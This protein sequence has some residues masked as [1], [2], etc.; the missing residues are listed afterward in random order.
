MA[1]HRK[2]RRTLG[3]TAFLGTATAAAAIALAAPATAAPNE[4]AGHPGLTSPDSGQPGLTS[5]GSD[6]AQP[7]LTSPAPAGEQPAQA[8]VAPADSGAY[9]YP[10]PSYPVPVV[11]EGTAPV[12]S[13][14][15]TSETPSPFNVG[16]LHAPTPVAPVTPVVP[17]Q[18]S[19]D[20][21]VGSFRVNGSAI[22]PKVRNSINLHTAVA[23]ANTE[24][25]WNSVGVAPDRS[26]R[27]AA[28][29]VAGAVGGGA[30]GA[31][32]VGAPVAAMGGGVGA[33]V[34]GGVGSL[35]LPGVG[36]AYGI[37]AGAGIG[38]AAA[39]I[40][41]ALVGGTLGAIGGGVGGALYGA[42]DNAQRIEDLPLLELPGVT[43]PAP[44]ADVAPAPAPAPIP[45]P[46]TELVQDYPG[47]N[48]VVAVDGSGQSGTAGV[49]AQVTSPSTATVSAHTVSDSGAPAAWTA[50][51]D[52]SALQNAGNVAHD[53]I[54][55]QLGGEQVTSAVDSV[56]AQAQQAVAAAPTEAGPLQFQF[57]GLTIDAAGQIRG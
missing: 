33:L 45:L 20:V 52:V 40:P 56:I 15:Q 39:G 30:L 24:N 22:D 13:D 47:V 38:A 5:Q 27:I 9:A 6:G 57:G 35:P 18:D 43:A 42:G 12:T 1:S 54:S 3:V 28:A 55:A 23:M 53:W 14:E 41:A 26:Q 44:G 11:Q 34:G 51:V 10:V 4:G 50:T 49:E 21:R 25:F 37:G 19:T 17:R 46:T 29:T 31:V 36:T 8:P 2:L 48:A 32:V 7:G 16:D